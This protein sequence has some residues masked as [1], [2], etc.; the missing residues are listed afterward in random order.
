MAG[1]VDIAV[2]LDANGVPLV[3]T[4]DEVAI[5]A[6]EADQT[7]VVPVEDEQPIAAGVEEIT[8]VAEL[9]GV[10]PVS[11]PEDPVPYAERVDMTN[12]ETV[13]Y[14]GEASVG[15]LEGAGTWRIRRLTIA[16]DN[17]VTTE[18]A[19]GSAAFNQIWDD[20]LGLSYS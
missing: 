8:I 12:N 13:I 20:R 18:W 4:V 2:T 3:V 16:G 5:Y 7:I 17:D 19:G 11:V 14:K 9:A 1:E 10:T 15:T 6:T